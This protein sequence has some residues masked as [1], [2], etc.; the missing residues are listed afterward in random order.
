MEKLETGLTALRMIE[1]S[2]RKIAIINKIKRRFINQIKNIGE[3]RIKQ[4]LLE[5]LKN[6]NEE[7]NFNDTNIGN[8]L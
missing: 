4:Y 6:L 1:R 2:N 7:M 5:Q 8:N 3:E